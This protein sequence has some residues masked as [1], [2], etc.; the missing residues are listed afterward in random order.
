LV[1]HARPAAWL[2]AIVAVAG[3]VLARPAGHF[4][5][6]A[7]LVLAVTVATVG[8][9]A[10][11]ALVFAIFMFVRRRRAAAGGCVTCQFRCQH[12]MSGR[13][14]RF[15]LVTTADRGPPAPGQP[16]MAGRQGGIPIRS[17]PVV[18]PVPTVRPDLTCTTPRWPDRPVYRL[19]APDLEGR[20]SVQRRERA[21]SPGPT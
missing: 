2:A 10:A 9:A 12:A 3:L 1:C 7:G 16:G 6:S 15:S 21:G 20:T 8:A 19:S 18:L 14:S 4:F 17:V 13:P 5:D 11:A